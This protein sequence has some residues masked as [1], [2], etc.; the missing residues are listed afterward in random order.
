MATGK[1]AFDTLHAYS[2][3]VIKISFMS[4]AKQKAVIH[5]SW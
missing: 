1:G 5:P 3:H 2:T 4:A